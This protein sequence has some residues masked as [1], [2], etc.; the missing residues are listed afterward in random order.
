MRRGIPYALMD[1]LRSRS[2]DA[3]EREAN[4]LGFLKDILGIENTVCL[5]DTR[6]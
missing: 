6:S 3:E 1:F 2:G 4:P 5:D